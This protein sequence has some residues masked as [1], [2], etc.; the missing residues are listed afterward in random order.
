L[1]FFG[2]LYS[3]S[4]LFPFDYC[5]EIVIP[6]VATCYLQKNNHLADARRRSF[7]ITHFDQYIKKKKDYRKKKKKEKD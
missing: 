5:C 2:N 6:S 4:F 7:Y 3:I 1:T